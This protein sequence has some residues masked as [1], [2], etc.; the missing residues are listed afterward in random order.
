[1]PKLAEN[2]ETMVGKEKMI[3]QDSTIDVPVVS[4][5]KGKSATP[6][7]VSNVSTAAIRIYF[8]AVDTT[9]EN[10]E[11]LKS[12]KKSI[13]KILNLPVSMVFAM[14]AGNT[15]YNHTHSLQIYVGRIPPARTSVDALIAS[16]SKESARSLAEALVFCLN[17]S[18]T[19]L[20]RCSAQ[21][22]TENSERKL[23]S[24]LRLSSRW[25]R[26]YPTASCLSLSADREESMGLVRRAEN[27]EL[28]DGPGYVRRQR[29]YIRSESRVDEEQAPTPLSPGALAFLRRVRNQAP[30]TLTG[31]RACVRACVRV[32]ARACSAQ[33]PVLNF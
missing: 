13:A 8:S 3:Y 10:E 18:G 7:N 17:D 20:H 31:L 27:L 9:G 26:R 33:L 24:P 29:R 14:V 32:C 1:M 4:L 2:F 16:C 5:V 25:F 15:T 11:L 21:T 30:F 12:L 19:P 22:S 28:A 6:L 23:A